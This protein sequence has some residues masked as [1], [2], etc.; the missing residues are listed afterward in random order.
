[1]L[2]SG[3]ITNSKTLQRCTFASVVFDVAALSG[4]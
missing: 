3:I 4:Q 2:D 1:M